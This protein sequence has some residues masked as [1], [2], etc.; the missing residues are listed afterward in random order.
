MR[1]VYILMGIMSSYLL[2]NLCYALVGKSVYDKD[3]WHT[4]SGAFTVA[5]TFIMGVL[6]FYLLD[7]CT[8]IKLS[9]GRES[10]LILKILTKKD[11]T[12][13]YMFSEYSTGSDTRQKMETV[14]LDS[15]FDKSK[16]W[17]DFSLDYTGKLSN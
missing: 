4:M 3:E 15:K 11:F 17:D 7:I 10:E 1:H 14:V 8:R 9:R 12:N 16:P 13:E 6:L 5:G 2:I